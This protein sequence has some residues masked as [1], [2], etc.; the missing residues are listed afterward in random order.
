MTSN[1]PK[2]S[3]GSPEWW[4]SQIQKGLA[5]RYKLGFESRW[6]DI[7]N[8]Y[9]N[10]FQNALEPRFNLIYMMASSMVPTLVFQAPSIV[11]SVRRPEFSYWGGFFDGIDNWLMDEL[12]V[13]EIMGEA[14]LET[15]LYNSAGLQLGYDFDPKATERENEMLF[16]NVDGTLDRTRKTNRPWI[17]LIPANKLVLAPGTK[18]MRNCRW[19]A[20]YMELPTRIV[21]LKAGFSKVEP[22]HIAGELKPKLAVDISGDE[23]YTCYYEV[24]DAEKGEVFC[25]DTDWRII[26]KA[27]Q[28]P[29]QVDG[30][31]LEVLTFNRGTDSLWNTPDSLY[32]ESQMLEG[33]E[34][35]TDGR[36]QRRL[37]LVKGFY[38]N[39][40]LTKEDIDKFI[41]GAPMTMIGV[42][43]PP[44]QSLGDI[45]QL[46]QPH[47]QMEY[48]EYEKQ[49]VNDA[50][51]LLGLGPNQ[52][53]S[54]SSGRR[55]KFEAQTVEDRSLL[56]TS[57]RRQRVATIIGNLTGKMNQLI[58]KYWK[59][60]VVAK[61]VGVEGAIHWVEAR[62]SEFE[63]IQ[64]QLITKVN[65]DSLTPVSRERRKEEMMNVL[66]LLT[67][68]QGANIMPIVQSFL[69]SFDWADVTQILPTAQGGQ[70]NMQ[71]FQAGQQAL[72]QN[73]ALPQMLGNNLGGMS[74]LVN[75]L[76]QG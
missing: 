28:D 54:F 64:S 15:F 73:P 30:L 33:N 69:Q 23:E 21:K 65:V 50:Q 66:Q 35:R 70:E 32:I 76:P 38:K 19:F 74:K 31:P 39:G 16:K 62:P 49:L 55:T 41:N 60:P 25:I 71:Q 2:Y 40:I 14:V 52:A 1:D 20:K 11:N 29:T 22:T 61:V 4:A 6:P 56:R 59:A 12:E 7:K 10:R 75:N 63:D 48:F 17:D 18:T 36:L 57:I 9:E 45:I 46:T 3:Y 43:V 51:L 34:C 24:H 13:Q 8:Y 53:G 37:A 27:Q 58:S 67:K 26:Q 5:Q 44:E 68:V 42:D 72:Q 47:V